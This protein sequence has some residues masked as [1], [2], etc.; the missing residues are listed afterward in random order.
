MKYT[1]KRLSTEEWYDVPIHGNNPDHHTARGCDSALYICTTDVKVGDRCYIRGPAG[2][3][4]RLEKIVHRGSEVIYYGSDGD[5]NYEE[6]VF[7][8]L[9]K[10]PEGCNEGDTANEVS[11]FFKNNKKSINMSK[12]R[13]NKNAQLPV[14]GKPRTTRKPV[15]QRG[16]LPQ[17]RG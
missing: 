16:N 6:C 13:K 14:G 10:A 2:Y 9:Y 11:A 8:R 5:E 7:K 17:R 15:P 4:T 12:K 1:I 3:Q